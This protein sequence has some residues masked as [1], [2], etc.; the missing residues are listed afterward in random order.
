MSYFY[1]NNKN[2]FNSI[3]AI[4]VRYT[5]AM[6][7]VDQLMQSFR[8]AKPYTIDWNYFWYMNKKGL[9]IFV[10]LPAVIPLGGMQIKEVGG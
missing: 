10:N 7:G 3:R 4:G 2:R 8:E 1:G 9:V 5:K 6:Q